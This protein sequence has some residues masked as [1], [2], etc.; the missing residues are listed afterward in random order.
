[1][2]AAPGTAPHSVGEA[3]AVCVDTVLSSTKEEE[4]PWVAKAEKT[5]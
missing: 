4:S 1:M 3:S 5:Q 2:A